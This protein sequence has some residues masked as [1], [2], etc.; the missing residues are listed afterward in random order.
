MTSALCRKD[1]KLYPCHVKTFSLVIHSAQKQLDRKVETGA[2][3]YKNKNWGEKKKSTVSEVSKLHRKGCFLSLQIVG[4][5]QFE[6]LNSSD[7]ALKS[8]NKKA[9]SLLNNTLFLSL[10]KGCFLS[11]RYQGEPPNGTNFKP[12]CCNVQCMGYKLQWIQNS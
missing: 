6:L 5:N 1:K 4:A 3:R 8:N 7:T 2:N 12:R 11:H 9:L 10:M